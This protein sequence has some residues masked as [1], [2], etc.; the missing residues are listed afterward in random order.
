MYLVGTDI[1]IDCLREQAPAVG[2]LCSVPPHERSAGS[3][4]VMQ[5]YEG[6]ADARGPG[7]VERLLA[8]MTIAYRDTEAQRAA[9]KFLASYRLSH[10]LG[11]ADAVIGATAAGLKVP[12]MTFNFEH[13]SVVERIDL[14]EP[15]IR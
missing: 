5:L 13:F 10:G 4:S 2:W 6:A 14:R 8:P 12:L 7:R 11:M 9:L 1:L 3:V 15:Y